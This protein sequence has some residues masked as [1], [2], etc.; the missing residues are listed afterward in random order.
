MDSP[1]LAVPGKA[2]QFALGL[3]YDP[4]NLAVAQQRVS[5]IRLDILSGHYDPSLAKYQSGEAKPKL[6]GAVKLFTRFIDWKAKQVQPLSLRRSLS[7]CYLA[8]R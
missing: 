2:L 1:S 6:I 7:R 5:Q 4:I 8:A 3:P